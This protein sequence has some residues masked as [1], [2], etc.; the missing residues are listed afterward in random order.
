MARGWPQL[1]RGSHA[2]SRD[3]AKAEAFW[4]RGLGLT[5]LHRAGPDAEGGHALLM[6]GWPGAARAPRT[7]RRPGRR[8]PP[9]PTEEDLPVLY[10]GA[11]ADDA[12]IRRLAHTGGQIVSATIP[13]WEH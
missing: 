2:P 12:L 13:Y 1:T 4:A 7:G 5:V 11:P 6:A 10:P 3:L 9:A 8:A